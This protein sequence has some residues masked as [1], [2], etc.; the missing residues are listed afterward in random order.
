MV[1]ACFCWLWACL[2][3]SQPAHDGRVDEQPG[4][5]ALTGNDVQT[6]GRLLHARPQGTPGNQLRIH[7]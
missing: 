5:L 6:G 3:V 1:A 2:R 4:G 7:L